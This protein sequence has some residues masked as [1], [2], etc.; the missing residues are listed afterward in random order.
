MRTTAGQKRNVRNNMTAQ[1]T[2]G[3]LAG[4]KAVSDDRG[5]IA[6]L[7]LDQRGI[8]KK[9]IACEKGV[10]DVPDSAVVEFKRLVTAALTKHASAILLDPE[11]G[12]PATQV[13]SRKGLFIAYEK[14]CY[15]APLPRMP[16]LY[17]AWS[18][19]RLRDE[20]GA[21]CIKVLLHYTPFDN[22]QINEKKKIWVQRVGDEC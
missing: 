18:V 4:L 10:A 1:L 6:A 13:R 15:G 8:L 12:L 22:L 21:D 3:K 20:V 14:S 2:P 5:V 16:E 11:Y 19:R 17:D 9:A 7:A